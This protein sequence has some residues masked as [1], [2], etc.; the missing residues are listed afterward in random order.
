MTKGHDTEHP[1]GTCFIAMPSGREQDEKDWFT[2]WYEEVIK[3]VV[4]QSGY[5][6]HL[7][8][9]QSTPTSITAEILTHLIEDPMAIVDIGGMT[10]DAAPNPNVWY[11][12]GIRHA[13]GQ[14]SVIMGWEGQQIPFDLKDQRALLERRTP[15]HF[16]TNRT[17]LTEF[18]AAARAGAYY[19]PIEA[20]AQREQLS[21][22]SGDFKPL[23]EAILEMQRDLAELKQLSSTEASDRLRDRLADMLAKNRLGEPP[24]G[25]PPEGERGL[26]GRLVGPLPSPSP[27][28]QA[29]LERTRTP[30]GK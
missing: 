11:E 26:L 27:A 5:V 10:P 17:Q 30:E 14:P 1:N 18:I 2:G 24:P 8:K 23:A 29:L 20:V 28:L 4:E 22:V 6:A 21:A 13:F 12:L 3:R 16:E 19:K 25:P 15:R 9:D 7:A